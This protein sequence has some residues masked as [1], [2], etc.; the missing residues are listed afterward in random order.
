MRF[1]KKK[2][3]N[4]RNDYYDFYQWR[5]REHELFNE[6]HINNFK[7]LKIDYISKIQGAKRLLISLKLDIL[8]SFF[9]DRLTIVLSKLLPSKLFAHMLIA[10]AQKK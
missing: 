5:L 10:I 9:F 4:K 8:P 6:L 3:N 7:V 2:I 1:Q